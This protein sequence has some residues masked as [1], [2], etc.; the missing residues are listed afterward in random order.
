MCR[1]LLAD[2]NAESEVHVFLSLFSNR[3]DELV[4]I[5]NI[6]T[7]RQPQIR[8]IIDGLFRDL[9]GFLSS[10]GELSESKW[11]YGLFFD[12]LYPYIPMILRALEANYDFA[13]VNT[14]LR[15]FSEFVMNKNQVIFYYTYIIHSID[16]AS[17]AYNLKFRHQ[18]GMNINIQ[19]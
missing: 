5:D 15:F 10:I 17:S 12:W 3:L 11:A 1:L 13:V 8:S 2:D 6:E 7:F 16:I 19:I 14:L 4:R 18:T 9:R